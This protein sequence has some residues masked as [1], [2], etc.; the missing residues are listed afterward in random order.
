MLDAFLNSSERL[1]VKFPEANYFT[2]NVGE[3]FTTFALFAL[4]NNVQLPFQI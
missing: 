2:D 3:L 4:K 1:S